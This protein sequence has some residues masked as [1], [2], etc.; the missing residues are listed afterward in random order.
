MISCEARHM[1]CIRC[2]RK[3]MNNFVRNQSEPVCHQEFCPYALSQQ[4]LFG[5]PLEHNLRH[6]LLK[7]VKTRRR[8]LCDRCFF[9]INL[10]NTW[11]FDEH[12]RTCKLDEAIPCEY[13]LCPQE[14]TQWEEH[15]R[16]CR[17]DLTNRRRKL[18]DFIVTRTKY[19]FTPQQID[20]FIEKRKNDGLPI[21]PRS[22]VAALAV[23]GKNQSSTAQLY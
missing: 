11:D 2:L 20:F 10:T 4:D 23:F 6:N 9:Y 21:D 14:I 18:V 19:P 22:I 17:S 16:Q 15:S 3:S 13:C 1:Y 7:L 12:L 8:P 5:L